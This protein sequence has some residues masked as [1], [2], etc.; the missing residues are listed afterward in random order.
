[1]KCHERRYNPYIPQETSA[2]ILLPTSDLISSTNRTCCGSESCVEGFGLFASTDN[3]QPTDA[4]T[5]LKRIPASLIHTRSHEFPH[6]PIKSGASNTAHQLNPRSLSTTI[7][8]MSIRVGL[9]DFRVVSKSCARCPSSQVS[10][11]NNNGSPPSAHPSNTKKI[12]AST[13]AS[14]TGT[15]AQDAALTPHLSPPPPRCRNTPS[16]PSFRRTYKNGEDSNGGE[17]HRTHNGQTKRLKLH[18]SVLSMYLST[19]P[20][21]R[22]LPANGQL[23]SFPRDHQL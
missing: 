11:L 3:R 4:K 21:V 20:E 6:T 2:E 23:S 1:M 13:N 17:G 16:S 12:R 8:A 19:V 7:Y 9:C 18:L 22:V 15:R 5:E 14:H 10:P